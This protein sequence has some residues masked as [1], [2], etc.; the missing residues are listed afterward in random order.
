MFV[1]GFID[2]GALIDSYC[3]VDTK[4][5]YCLVFEFKEYID[6]EILEKDISKLCKENPNIE[7]NDYELIT[8]FL[9]ENYNIESIYWFEKGLNCKE[10]EAFKE[11]GEVII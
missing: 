4:N 5:G 9:E 1:K 6:S 8:E 3:I 7:Y 11:Q 10:L 2:N